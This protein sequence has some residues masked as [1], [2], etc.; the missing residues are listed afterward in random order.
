MFIFSGSKRHTMSNM[1]N[2]SSK[3]FY[4]SAITMGLSPIPADTYTMFACR[5]F[6]ER[7]KR[8]KPDVVEKYIRNLTVALGL[9]R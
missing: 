3:P 2:S 1:F 8:I 6:E 5:M 9:Y 4:Q 7:E